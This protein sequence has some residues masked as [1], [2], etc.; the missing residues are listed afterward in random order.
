MSEPQP[1][2]RPRH[3]AKPRILYIVK[4]YPQLSQTYIK[5][6][7]KALRNDYEIHIV[8][9]SSP[10]VPDPDHFPFRKI[11]D[12]AGLVAAVRELKPQILHSHY[13]VFA[14]LLAAVATETGT[15]FTIRSHSF[16]TIV[17]G[18]AMPR[19]LREMGRLL[20]TDLCLGVLC[21]PFVRPQL[22]ALGVPEQRLI[23]TP[24]VVD[25]DFFYDRSANTGGVMNVGAGI[26]KKKMSDFIEMAKLVPD[27]HFDLFAIGHDWSKLEKLNRQHGE[28]ATVKAPVPFSEMPKCYK[29][30][31]WLAYTA[32]PVMK[33]VGWPM[34]I[35]EAQASGTVVC[36]ANI[37][38]DL[39]EYVGDAGFLYDSVEEA[40]EILRQPVPSEKRE[41]GFEQAR[42]SDIQRHKHLLTDLW[43][44]QFR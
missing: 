36:M 14:D 19:H 8:A 22:Q 29:E 39:K 44:P 34:A 32:C 27:L 21:F 38:P 17:T 10:N 42:R 31:K 24:P 9:L 40:A 33:T 15:P 23:C 20:G 35:A 7:I 43:E 6:E 5:N 37:R 4:N 3:G 16:D 18:N 25:F 13:L 2:H 41:L 12:Q 26:P 30:H 11:S 28:P 1:N